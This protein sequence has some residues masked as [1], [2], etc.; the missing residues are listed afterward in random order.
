MRAFIVDDV[1]PLLL[2]RLERA[3]IPFEYQPSIN[4]EAAISQLH[5]F[6]ILIIRSKFDVDKNL[7]N[8]LSN[9]KIIARAGAG[10]DNIDEEEAKKLGII[11]LNAPEGNR[12]AVAEHMMGMLLSLLNN[13]RT[14]HYEIQNGSWRREENRGIELQGKTVALIGYGNNGQ[15]MA[16]CLSGFG[17]KVI[18]YDKY[19]TGFSDEYAKEVSMEEVVKQADILSFHIPLTRE[20]RGLVDD[21]YLFHFKKPI[22]LLNGARGE[23]VK[24]PSLLNY[25][26]KGKIIACGLDVLPFEKF[27]QLKEQEWFEELSQ[28]PKVLLSPHVAG[29]THE[30][31]IKI[32]EVLGE[33]IVDKVRELRD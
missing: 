12:Q 25:L 33:K 31:Y 29:W 15:A 27:P 24:I 14:A 3:E 21:E 13:L 22:I 9:I 8:T 32:V 17:V 23:I 19:K 18:A 4:K 7:L 20:T 5:N 6:E 2:E 26:N 28:H 30:S 10:L 1:H 11:L 16:R